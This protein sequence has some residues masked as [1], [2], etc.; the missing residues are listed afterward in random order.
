MGN[1]SNIPNI[2][3]LIGVN[4]TKIKVYFATKYAGDD[5]DPYEKNYTNSYLNPKTIQGYVT[6]I[7]PEKLV[8]KEYGLQEM[9]AIEILCDSRYK[10]WFKICAKV[11][12]GTDEYSVFKVGTGSRVLIQDRPGNL[13]RVVLEKKG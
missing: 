13:I 8:W 10:N 11:E 12:V 6:Q 9:G 4:A 2:K 5:F 1:F 3:E 7:S